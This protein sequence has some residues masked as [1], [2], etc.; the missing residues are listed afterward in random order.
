MTVPR[1]FH[2]QIKCPVSIIHCVEDIGYGIEHT[3]DL[4]NQLTEAGVKI[5]LHTAPGP[6]F[7][8]LEGPE[9]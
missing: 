7:P 1:F 5:T 3:E 4:A 6:H 8:V 9:E 2:H